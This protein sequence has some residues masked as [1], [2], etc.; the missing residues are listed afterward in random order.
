MPSHSR[1]VAEWHPSGRRKQSFNHCRWEHFLNKNRNWLLIDAF[2]VDMCIRHEIE[3]IIP[4][5]VS[6]SSV[7]PYRQLQ[8]LG[9]TRDGHT[10]AEFHICYSTTTRNNQNTPYFFSTLRLLLPSTVVFF[11]CHCRQK[12]C[13][14]KKNNE[15]KSIIVTVC[16]VP[17]LARYGE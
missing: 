13:C 12:H 8:W 9:P 16:M 15:W 1:G 5:A 17:R 2:F 6:A 3:I 11:A 14:Q 4:G 7:G 10:E